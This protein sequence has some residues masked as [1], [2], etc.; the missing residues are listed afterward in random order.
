MANSN[1]SKIDFKQLV[2]LSSQ[3]RIESPLAKYNSI[4]QLTCIVCNQIVKSEVMWNAHLSSKVHLDNKNMLKMKLIG[5]QAKPISNEPTKSK[6]SNENKSNVKIFI[7]K[8]FLIMKINPIYYSKVSKRSITTESG[9]IDKSEDTNVSNKKQKLENLIKKTDSIDLNQAAVVAATTNQLDAEPKK[10]DNESEKSNAVL[11]LTGTALPEGF[12]DD[13]DLDA[14]ARG[15]SRLEN[16]EAE[17]EEFKKIIQNEEVKSDIMIEKDDALRDV[18][19]DIEEV[20]ELISRWT[21]IE[22]L[23]LR[24]EELLKTRKQTEQNKIIVD[25]SEA[26]EEAEDDDSDIDLENDINLTLRSKNRF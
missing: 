17:Y 6:S 16:L 26:D 24:R 1:D 3:K 7:Q 10:S 21:K 20:D 4:G 5:E 14:K 23:H 13:P 25:K 2:G 8:L 9:S 11:N 19:R 12:F 15:F 18:H 22:N